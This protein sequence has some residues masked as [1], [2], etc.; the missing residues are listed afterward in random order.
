MGAKTREEVELR[1]EDGDA[2]LLLERLG[3]I[4]SLSFQKRRETWELEGC[5]VELDE[6][7]YLGHFVEIEGPAEEPILRVRERL[8]LGDRPMIK[9]GY[10]ELLMSYLQTHNI[11]EREI[12]FRERSV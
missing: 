8:G 2:A 3:F 12:V 11:R 1:V 4:P 10:V 9:S 7:P 5:K 6:L